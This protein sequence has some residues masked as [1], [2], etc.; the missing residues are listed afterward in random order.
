MPLQLLL[1]L[2]L[3]GSGSSLRLW[4]AWE[5]GIK[6]APGRLLAR[7]RRQLKLNISEDFDTYEGYDGTDPPEVLENSR[8]S[9]T[10][11]PQLQVLMGQRDSAGL[12]SPDPGTPGVARGDSDSLGAGGA[13]TGN[14]STELATQGIPVTLGPQPKEPVT[15]IPPIVEALSTEGAPLTKQASM[16]TL[17]MAPTVTAAPTTQP[18]ATEALSTSPEATETLSMKSTVTGPEVIEI[19]STVAPSTE[20]TT[21]ET[22][23]TDPATTKAQSTQPATTRGFTTALLVPTDLH[24]DT[25]VAVSDSSDGLIKQWKN[26]QSIS[27][28]SSVSPGLTEDLNFIPVK[29]CLLAILVLALVATTFLVCTVV[30]A[31][32]LSRKNHMYPVRNYSPTEMICISSLLPEGGEGPAVTANG[33]L[34]TTKGP[35]LKEGSGMDRDGDDLTLHSFLP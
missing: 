28:G 9:V 7:G 31:V 10:L 16:K 30:L 1:L 15:T 5:D 3:L 24:R 2:I 26:S 4:E 19:L 20:P 8:E 12:E 25:T 33:D 29:H 27:P 17:S 14:L 21:T 11:S 35:G 18:A 23:S 32:R 13:A 34:P 6:E 22:W